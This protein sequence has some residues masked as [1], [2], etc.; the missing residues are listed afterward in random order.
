[1]ELV[2]VVGPSAK[3]PA[4]PVRWAL[5]LLVVGHF[6][7]ILVAVTSTSTPGFRGSQLATT[8]AEHVQPYLEATFFNN[9]YRFFAPNPNLPTLFWMRLQNEAGNV[10]WVELPGEP[11]SPVLRE[12]YQRRLNLAGQLGV[13]MLPD[14]DSVGRTRFTPLGEAW[15]ASA[16]RHVCHE[17]AQAAGS[18]VTAA[19]VYILQHAVLT[20]EQVREGWTPIDLRTYQA[21][22][23]G[24]FDAEGRRQPQE[25]RVPELAMGQLVAAMLATDVHSRLK[26]EARETILASLSLPHPVAAFV[27]SHPELLDPALTPD[28]AAAGVDQLLTGRR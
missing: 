18:A 14:V 28:E 10:R 16:L 13:Q 15:L 22:Y 5:S 24:G 26:G 3:S 19:D 25:D 9:G 8:A 20:P 6:F 12:T 17:E 27:R 23:V 7:A 11:Q 4:W 21:K 2:G 1:M